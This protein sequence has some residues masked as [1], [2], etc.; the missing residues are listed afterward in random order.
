MTRPRQLSIH[1]NRGNGDSLQEQL[2]QNLRERIVAGDI[3]PGVAL[4]SSRELA[5]DLQVSRNTVVYAYDRLMG[6]GYLESRPRSGIFVNPKIRG[7]AGMGDRGSNDKGVSVA[8]LDKESTFK[9]PVPFRPCQP[10][11]R[12]FPLSQWNRIRSRILRSTGTNLLNYQSQ[13]ALGLPQLRQA[14]SRYLESRSVECQWQQIA[15]TCGSQQALYL[16]SRILLRPGDKVLMEEPGYM[17]ARQAFELAGAKVMTMKV[18]EEGAIPPSSTSQ[19]KLIYTT[20]SRQFP[21]GASMPVA[22]RIEM[23]KMARRANAWLLEDDYDSEFRYSRPPLPSLHSL[24]ERKEV[25]YL[26]TMS[27]VLFPSLRIGYAVL[28]E[29]LLKPFEA[30]RLIVEDH[31]PLIDQ[32]VMAE[33]IETGWFFRHIR[34]CRKVYATRLEHF[35]KT[36]QRAGVPLRFPFVEGGMNQTGYFLD[37][38]VDAAQVSMLL[39]E[40]YGLDIPPLSLYS[41]REEPAGLVF[42]FTAF[43]ARITTTNITKLAQG[44]MKIA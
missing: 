32:A 9:S 27:K 40:T 1:L 10:D 43:D 24:D 3:A 7:A 44:L 33:F 39:R 23:L 26:G 19:F 41:Q 16:L 15:I 13:F 37:E 25:I 18:D 6:E 35:L 14:L 38:Q 21:T 4:P 11:V 31:G 8:K 28:P 29:E 42:G 34:R 12:L 30:L 20:P 17:G 22:R 2:S 5:A 36:M